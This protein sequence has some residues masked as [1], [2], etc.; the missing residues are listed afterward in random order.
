MHTSLS[1]SRMY[2]VARLDTT[3]PLSTNKD[4]PQTICWHAVGQQFCGKRF[5]LSPLQCPV[6]E[7]I[8]YTAYVNTFTKGLAK[9]QTYQQLDGLNKINNYVLHTVGFVGS[10]VG[11]L[12]TSTPTLSCSTKGIFVVCVCVCLYMCMCLILC[13]R[14]DAVVTVLQ[15]WIKSPGNRQRV[16]VNSLCVCFQQMFCNGQQ[17]QHECIA[18]VPVQHE[19][20]IIVGYFR[21]VLI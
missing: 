4:I 13:V 15:C 10:S 12:Q 17:L 6:W 16:L 3:H 8:W 20:R 1:E 11:H 9:A 18:C 14:M 7:L 2:L 5:S 19:C 21:G